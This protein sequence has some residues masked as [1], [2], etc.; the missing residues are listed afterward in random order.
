MED[1]HS[2]THDSHDGDHLF[3]KKSKKK[4]EKKEPMDDVMGN[5]NTN[6]K[7]KD[8]VILY[9]QDLARVKKQ[10]P[11][12]VAEKVIEVDNLDLDENGEILIDDARVVPVAEEIPLEKRVFWN[13][14]PS[15]R[16]TQQ[17]L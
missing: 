13:D 9:E 7:A 12:S 4:K 14:D 8:G 2:T 5:Q 15:M 3:T 10:P 16:L 11:K 17:G 1:I 6:L